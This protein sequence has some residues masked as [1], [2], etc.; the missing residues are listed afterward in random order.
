MSDYCRECRTYTGGGCIHAEEEETKRPDTRMFK[1]DSWKDLTPK[2][3]ELIIEI[4]KNCKTDSR[5]QKMKNELKF[6]LKMPVDIWR[7]RVR[8]PGGTWVEQ[9]IQ[10]QLQFD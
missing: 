2:H 4:Y 6:D 8:V 3:W 5:Y 10:L 9:P 7:Q 1:V